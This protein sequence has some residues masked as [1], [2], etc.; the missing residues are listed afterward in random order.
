MWQLDYE[1]A[2][3]SINR[4]RTWHWAPRSRYIAQV[5]RDAFL[6][7]R[8][9]KIPPQRRIRVTAQPWQARGPLGDQGNH[10]PTVKAFVDGIVDA[11]VVD[12]D[13]PDKVVLELRAPLRNAVTGISVVISSYPSSADVPS[14]PT[15]GADHHANE[16]HP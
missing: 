1:T 9:A 12:N 6:L 10:L 2:L 4:E 5:R 3:L 15:E 16:A 14:D 11:G 7:A 8:E 13:T